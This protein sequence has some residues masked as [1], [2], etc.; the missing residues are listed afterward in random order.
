MMNCIDLQINGYKGVDFSSSALT[1]EDFIRTCQHIIHDGTTH[2]LPTLITSSKEV[3]RQNLK[4]IARASNDPS[5][6]KAI[7][8]VHLE[9]PFLS[10]EEGARGA[11]NPDWML[12]PD[13]KF[14]YELW[15]WSE[16]K[17]KLMTVA[18]E[19]AGASKICREAKKLGIKI[20]LGHQM[21]SRENITQ[22]IKNGAAA[23]THLGNGL[24]QY[25]HR[26]QNPIWT[27]LADERLWTMMITDGHH[28]PPEL[29]KVIIKAKGTDRILI[30]SDAAPI[31]GF[32]PGKYS[33]LGND[34][35][36]AENG[37][38]YNPATGYMVG[39]SANMPQCIQY[40]KS[41]DC[42][43]DAEL[44]QIAYQNPLKFLETYE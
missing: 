39:S 24:P 36:L 38:L 23:C 19:L 18:A 31:A 42:L 8:G 26:F 30:V 5:I 16:G 21:A 27:C 44:Q 37:Y 7:L 12:L 20:S 13:I 15:D 35:V 3:Y 11:H 22:L 33:T 9:G 14:L 29:I 34:V 17:I 25:I 4:I 10:K 32:P 40:L 2:F 1:E 28:L 6:R 41:L 43:S